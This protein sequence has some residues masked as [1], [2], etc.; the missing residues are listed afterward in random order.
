MEQENFSAI[1]IPYQQTEVVLRTNSYARHLKRPF[2]TLLTLGLLLLFGPLM[3]VIALGIK[4]FSPGPILYRQQRVGKH[5]KPFSMLKF[6]SMRLENSP[7]LHREYVQRLI[8]ENVDPKE[9]QTGSL[10]LK[11]D[12]RITGLGKILRKFSLDEL[13]QLFNVLRGDMA[14][15]GPRPPL[16]YE[17][18]VYSEWHKQRLAVLPG[19][20]GLW[21][22]VAHNTCPFDEMV[23]LDLE[24]IRTMSLWNDLKLMVMTPVEMLRGKGSG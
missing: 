22:V 2:E 16:P 10:K 5:G 17:Y 12:P 9:F 8:L 23:R 13:P 14:L 3:L 4:L 18:E 1:S 11:S 20:T 19:I 7:S 6:R 15:L 21:Q 24:Y